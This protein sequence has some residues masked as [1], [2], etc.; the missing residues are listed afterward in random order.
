MQAHPQS[1]PAAKT[2]SLPRGSRPLHPVRPPRPPRPHNGAAPLAE[3]TGLAHDAGNLLAGLGLYCDLLDR[4]GV[5]RPEHRH[6]LTEL[7][8][9]ADRSARLIDRLLG[10]TTAPAALLQRHDRSRCDL[11]QV[12]RDL[13]PLLRT[14]ARPSVSV[15]VNAPAALAAPAG[16]PREAFER[17]LVNLVRNAAQAGANAHSPAPAAIRVTLRHVGFRIRLTV[18]D[19]GPGMPSA[20]ADTLL[21]PSPLP[22]GARRGL[23]HRIVH[24]LAAA[25]GA[26]LSVRTRA[27][28]GTTVAVDWIDPAT[29]PTGPPADHDQR[30]MHAC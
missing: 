22:H 29:V 16:L 14:L 20:A 21:T 11:A 9:L 5:L 15:A 3:S 10:Q 2:P 12:L 26:R 30:E 13:A 4:P 27:G 18:Q 25:T 24:E 23:G 28:R 8:A 7:R 6:Y 17:I 1:S 19:N